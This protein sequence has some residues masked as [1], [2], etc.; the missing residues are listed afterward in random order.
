MKK[1]RFT[2]FVLIMCVVVLVGGNMV[3]EMGNDALG[4]TLML[5]SVVV[6]ITVYIAEITGR[7]GERNGD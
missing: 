3:C 4:L 7:K 6:F 1:N 2:M 5:S